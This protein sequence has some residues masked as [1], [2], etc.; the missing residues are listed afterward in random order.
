MPVLAHDAVTSLLRDAG[1]ID[2]HLSA[3]VV[4]LAG[5]RN[6]ACRAVRRDAGS[7]F[8]PSQGHRDKS[9]R[10]HGTTTQHLT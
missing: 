10:M 4:Q 5:H 9:T 2:R 3:P 8:D 7:S 1:A 6:L